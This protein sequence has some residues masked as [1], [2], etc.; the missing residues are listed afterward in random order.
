MQH[1]LLK[2]RDAAFAAGSP[3]ETEIAAF[4]LCNKALSGAADAMERIRALAK[5][6]ELWSMLVR[7][8]GL[9][10]NRLPADVKQSLLGVAAWSMG[11]SVR[12]MGQSDLPVTPL[13]EVNNN[14]AEGLRAQRPAA[15]PPPPLA[16]T[17]GGLAP[18][19][20]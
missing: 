13:V 12:A 20:A 6:H 15:A 7:D 3:Q 14:I 17:M 4:A 1:G 11:Y 18:V 5:N 2:Y 8:L 9:E 10:G 16:S 19:S